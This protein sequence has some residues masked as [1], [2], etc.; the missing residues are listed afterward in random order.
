LLDKYLPH[1]LGLK[2]L[3]SAV[4]LSAGIVLAW[5][6]GYGIREIGIFIFIALN[7]ILLSFILYLRTNIAAIGKYRWD[8]MI[9]V[10]D[11]VI[12]ILVLGALLYYGNRDSFTLYHYIFAQTFALA[13]VLAVALGINFRLAGVKGVRMSR[14]FAKKI[15]KDSL[16]YS[17]I[18]ILMALYM[19]MDGFMLERML[20][21]PVEAGKYAAAF[22]LYEAFN[23]IGY[24][25][26]VLL[27]PMFASLLEN[28]RKL[29]NLIHTSHNLMLVISLTAVV[30]A[31]MYGRDIMMFLYP[32]SYND[33][34]SKILS[35]LMISFFA[36]NLTYIYGTLLTAAGRLSIFNKIVAV[37]VVIN[38]VLNFVL[39]PRYGAFGAAMATVVTQYFVLAAQYYIDI[40]SFALDFDFRLFIKRLSYAFSVVAVFYIIRYHFEAASII[41]I[42]LS[43]IISLLLAIITGMIKL[44]DLK[45]E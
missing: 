11:K 28:K 41:R 17:L 33:S 20:P 12:L 34:Y 42:A 14:S 26:A 19:K 43:V 5:I 32:E 29:K 4:Y 35:I 15:L 3:L 2:L 39:I 36:V 18:F 40:R 22:R 8:S 37:G 24:L 7:L 30:V 23:N 21:T 9:S 25:F 1:I 31:I 44:S 6:F 13:L 16:P 10:L 27:L 38:F 45:Q